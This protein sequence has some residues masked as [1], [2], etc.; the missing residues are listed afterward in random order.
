MRDTKFIVITG[1]VISG[2]GK[3]ISTASIGALYSDSL[4]VVPIKCDGYL[5]VDPGIM[6]PFQHGEVFVL[7][8]GGEVDMDF[9]HYERF[10]NI[11]T[12][13]DQ[14]LTMGRV[15]NE[16]IS[17]E[18][19]G[20]FLG[21]TVQ[22]IPH[23][24]THIKESFRRIS[25]D[26]DLAIIEIGGTV[27]D[28]E[29]ELYLET[30]RQ[31][32]AEL[33]SG[34][35]ISIHLGYIPK[36]EHLGEQKSKPLQ[37]SVTL[38]NRRGIKPDIIIGRS[39][40]RITDELKDK[41]RTFCGVSKEAVISGIHA[42]T[43]YEVPLMYCR[44]LVPGIISSK[45]GIAP[46][47]DKEEWAR[48]VV[49]ILKPIRGTK[50]IAICGKYTGLRDS[51]ASIIEAITHAAVSLDMRAE[52]EFVETSNESTIEDRLKGMDGIIVPGGFGHRGGEGKIRAVQYA[53]ENKLPFL[54]LCLGLQMAVVEF[55][56]NK[57]KIPDA[58]SEEF[59]RQ[60]DKKIICVLEEHDAEQSGEYGASMRL[61]ACTAHLKQGTLVRK[62]YLGEEK[63]SERHRHRYEVNPK[64]HQILQDNGLILSGM[65]P[66]GTLVE[67]IELDNHP[68]FVATQAH[69]EFKSRLKRPA[70]LFYGFLEAV[71]KH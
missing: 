1:G 15:Y 45:L 69:P 62:L 26:A 44:E 22:L 11:T 25:Q 35:F 8:D 57:C 56:R 54:G 65:S 67:F 20:G 47:I 52:I 37:Q 58:C 28:M 5:N 53:R 34:R 41:I 40:E 3:G 38:L 36:P 70:P 66:D 60:T 16:V 13:H 68:F 27:G 55:A 49:K 61:G 63:I 30:V 33:G 21:K 7:E 18:R 39:S 4:N 10:M 6:S 17:K 12:L 51:Y 43:I 23:V 59:E 19:R 42:R 29:N 64:Y 32:Q 46:S 9:G 31:M 71:L 14:N 48:Y 2:L 50:K 24:T